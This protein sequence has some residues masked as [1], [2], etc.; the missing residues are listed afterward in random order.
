MPL[1]VCYITPAG[2]TVKIADGIDRPMAYSSVATRDA[3]REQH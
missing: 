2:K 1:A 3:L